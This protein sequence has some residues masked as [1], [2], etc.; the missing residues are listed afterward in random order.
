MATPSPAFDPDLLRRY[1]RPGPRYTSYPTAPQFSTDFQSGELREMAAIS[2]GDPIPRPLSIYVHVPFCASPCFYCGCNRIITRD[3]ARGDAYLTR[4]Y[5]EI[6]MMSTL[7]DRDREVAQLHLGGGTPNFL[8]PEQIAEVVDVIHR[9]FSFARSGERD[10]SI[11]LDPRFVSPDD[12]RILAEA[13]FNR[14]SLGVQDFDPVV[15]QAVNRI[16]SVEETLAIIEACRKHGLRS[17]NVDLIYGLP[18]QSPEGFERTLDITL[19]ARPD[20]LAIYSYAHLPSLFRPQQRIRSEDLP[21]PAVKLGLLQRAI[22]R[23]GEAG[24]VYIGMDHFALPEDDLAVA[25][26]RGGLHRNFMGYTTCADSDLIGLGVSAISHIGA[27]FSQNP[28]DLPSWEN[29]ID[30]GRLPVWRGMRLD[31][32][33]L[34][35]ADVIQQLMCHGEIDIGVVE[36]RHIIDFAD[37]FGQAL[38]RLQP[39]Q[40]DGLVDVSATHI[41]ATSRGRLL[42]RI[43]ASCFDRYLPSQPDAAPGQFSRTV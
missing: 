9:H 20:R 37:Y 3:K 26:A 15:Q 30:E 12:I 27:S 6:G 31:A 10:C 23:L 19:A 41:R 43:L 24:Y 22:E 7:F 32:D 16:Q 13:G 5:R 33:D 1:D 21:S 25:Q 38:Q 35:R 11:E 2:N 14:A 8:A 29:A 34:V 40:H 42:L 36:R 17:V 28:R 18:L 4:L 39:L